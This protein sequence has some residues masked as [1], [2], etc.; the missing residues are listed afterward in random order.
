MAS[1]DHKIIANHDLW[2]WTYRF[3]FY[4]YIVTW[5]VFGGAIRIFHLMVSGVSRGKWIRVI[6]P[7][8]RNV[9]NALIDIYCFCF[10]V[11]ASRRRLFIQYLMN[12]EREKGERSKRGIELNGHYCVVGHSYSR[13]ETLK[14]TINQSTEILTHGKWP[15]IR[16]C[17]LN[18]QKQ[19]WTKN[20]KKKI[21]RY[22]TNCWANQIMVERER[23]HCAP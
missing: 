19:K 11:S 20:G 15:L 10:R 21:F 3:D 12:L 22:P 14:L 1:G 9:K 2:L 23:I 4:Y 8:T 6:S 5:S 17:A 7:A 13:F 18:C 16:S